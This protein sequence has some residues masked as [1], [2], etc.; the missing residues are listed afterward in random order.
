MDRSACR[1]LSAALLALGVCSGRPLLGQF[2]SGLTSRFELSDAVRVGE[3]GPE[4]V[5]Q[6]Q[7]VQACLADQQWDEAITTLQRV[8]EDSGAALVQITPLRY[9]PV[10]DV[11]HAQLAALPPEALAAYRA[12]VDPLAQEWYE[13]ARTQ[14][15]VARLRELIDQYFCSSFGDD[16]LFLLGELLLEAGDV[17][18][19]RRAWE[20]LLETPPLEI[21]A[22]RYA[23]VRNDPDL[24]AEQAALLDGSYREVERGDGV[25]MSMPIELRLTATEAQ[26]L[27]RLWRAHG[28]TSPLLCYPGTE[29]PLAEIRARI[30]WTWLLQDPTLAEQGW[31]SFA[32]EFGAAQGVWGGRRV[33]LRDYLQQ[34]LGTSWRPDP[35]ESQ[36]SATYT[37]GGNAERN[38][39][40]P[41][42][43][44]LDSLLWRVTLPKAPAAELGYP[45]SPV[46]EDRS[47]RLSYHPVVAGNLVLLCTE[48]T[49]LAF[50]L[51]TGQPAWG[52]DPV[53]YRP[54]DPVAV[55]PRS[56]RLS[57]L[58][59]PRF[60]LTVDGTRL[61]AR[62]GSPVTGSAGERA[63]QQRPSRI[64][65]LDLAGEGRLVWELEPP[66]EGWAF[67]GS[68]LCDGQNIYVGLRRSET[69]QQA[70]VAAYDAATGL[71]RWQTFVCGGETPAR[72][73]VDEITH[74]LL[75]LSGDTLYY[76]TN[77]GAIVALRTLDGGILWLTRYPRARGDLNQRAAH[78]YRDLTPCV[79][80]QGAV[81]AAPSDSPHVFALDSA[82]GR[83]LWRTAAELDDPVH[84]L[85][86]AQGR[87]IASGNQLWWI[88]L[89]TGKVA[90]D[91][92]PLGGSPRGFG[93]GVLVGGRIWW[94]TR[95][96]I[97]V[98]D[99][100][101]GQ[102]LRTFELAARG[103]AGGNL[104]AVG[105]RLL[106]ASAEEIVCLGAAPPLPPETELESLPPAASE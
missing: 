18:G 104:L 66:G 81:I 8:M 105:E 79:C 67:E 2:N 54:A 41:V 3:A 76:N 88:D 11:C 49:V 85:G 89:A 21:E 61:F 50:D 71:P 22:D 27:A 96:T 86:A 101:T 97:Y 77:L 84:L 34:A 70:Y 25:W 53:I 59:T 73:Q 60:T 87:V 1:M 40:A 23:Q 37:L 99:E 7:R 45:S 95:E 10:R 24:P 28:L 65:C 56:A 44:A 14:R 19:A 103:L 80:V 69:T 62:V 5:A 63:G 17:S 91:E 58:G 75:T 102:L 12:R 57:S 32:Q 31:T 48:H 64:V 78:F 6:L 33:V 74:N 4:V 35:T 29:L 47:D 68:P 55:A 43:P 30:L 93:R 39:T 100:R 46:A 20:R 15:D 36:P 42:E 26:T 38:S 106:I 13:A 16:A 94:P 92:F 98:L 52:S 9:L 83:F 82:S 72:G 90:C 51:R